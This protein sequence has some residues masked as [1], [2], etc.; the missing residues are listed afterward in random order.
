LTK[1]GVM[2]GSPLM[3]KTA[4]QARV[5]FELRRAEREPAK[6]LIEAVVADSGEKVYLY[7]DP[8][9]SNGDIVEAIVVAGYDNRSFAVQITFTGEAAQRMAKAT[10]QLIGKPVAIL[11]DGKVTSA[12]TIRSRIDERAEISGHFTREEAER[13]AT[14]LNSK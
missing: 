6:E 4:G 10:E 3:E 8:L 9:V 13:I 1:H 5:K 11:L 14:G 12:P 2:Q 7:R